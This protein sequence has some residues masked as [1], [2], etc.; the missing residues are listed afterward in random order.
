MSVKLVRL[1]PVLVLVL[2]FWGVL[3][4]YSDSV[5]REIVISPNKS[6]PRDKIPEAE[7]III[8]HTCTDLELIPDYWLAQA[9]ELAFHYAHTSHG[10]QIISGLQALE[11]WNPK[12]AYSVFNA[13]AVPPT[14]LNCDEGSLCIFNGNPPETYI[15]PDDYWSSSSG[16]D[17]T[18]AVASTGLFDYSMWSWC[19]EQSS[20]PT[21][22]VESYLNTWMPLKPN[23][24][25]CVSST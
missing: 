17:R 14:T 21:T 16:R 12:Y 19:G 24:P 3:V 13:G 10:S 1:V 18:R 7:A 8:D 20:N 11:G 23:I 5:H 25:T 15:T 4:A 9:K 6:L 22:T 2:I